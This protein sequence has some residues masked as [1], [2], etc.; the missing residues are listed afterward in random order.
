MVTGS[1]E[2]HDGTFEPLEV[3]VKGS[4]SIRSTLAPASFALIDLDL[5]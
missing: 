3:T 4:K 1:R 2:R 5:R